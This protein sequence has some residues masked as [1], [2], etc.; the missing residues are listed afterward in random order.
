MP[1]YA[2]A[3]RRFFAL[4]T[5]VVPSAVGIEDAFEERD[6]L[7]V[8]RW[9]FTIERF[10]NSM[11][12]TYRDCLATA[13]GEPRLDHEEQISQIATS[14]IRRRAVPMGYARAVLERLSPSFRLVLLTKGEYELQNR[15]VAESGLG[16]FFERVMIVDH[17]DPG[18]FRQ[19]VSELKIR[20]HLAWSVGDSLRSDIRPALTAGLRA[21]W[22][23]QETWSY[24]RELPG[25][26]AK[27]FLQ[28]G[29]LRELP[30]LLGD[31]L[32]DE[33]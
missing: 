2:D 31:A 13:G 11:V 15:R 5:K 27:R 22:I 26:A 32:K 4:V 17:K 20:P 14:V 30:R 25:G 1:L 7:N 6:R 24:E 16:K 3:K 18:A 8:A 12:E 10:R 28:T 33:A 21:I 9:G 19:L 29:S 23:P